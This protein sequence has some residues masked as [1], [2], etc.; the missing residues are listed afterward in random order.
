MGLGRAVAVDS[1]GTI[2]A[3]RRRQI[4]GSFMMEGMRFAGGHGRGLCGLLGPGFQGKQPTDEALAQEA[5]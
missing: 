3:L 5:N 2:G 4:P 1:R